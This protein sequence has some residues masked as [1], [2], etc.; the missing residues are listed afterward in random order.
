MTRLMGL[1]ASLRLNTVYE[2][3][4]T[5]QKCIDTATIQGG[6]PVRSPSLVCAPHLVIARITCEPLP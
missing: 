1:F 6:Y 4:E 5:F 3:M 2:K